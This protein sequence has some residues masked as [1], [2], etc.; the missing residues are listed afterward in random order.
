M[1]QTGVKIDAEVINAFNAFKMSS[2]HRYLYFKMSDDKKS[3][4]LEKAAPFSSTYADFLKDLPANDCRYAVVNF[5]YTTE[6]D[7]HRSKIV[8][9]NWSPE[10]APVKS[11][12]VYAGTKNDVRK[13]LVGVSIEV[14]GTDLSEVDETE[15]F[16]RLKAVSK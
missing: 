2:E 5:E 7:G 16:N 8:F 4:V 11:K 9:V 10:G 12:M 14:Q 15:V 13:A 3:V 1:S 6:S